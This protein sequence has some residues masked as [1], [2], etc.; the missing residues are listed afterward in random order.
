MTAKR[1]S[2]RRE[3]GVTN[4]KKFF[5][6]FLLS[7]CISIPQID[8]CTNIS[9]ENINPPYTVNINRVT[10]KGINVDDN[11]NVDLV[12]VDRIVDDVESCLNETFPDRIPES[13]TSHAWCYNPWEGNFRR[14]FDRNCLTIKIVDT[15]FLSNDG[16]QMVLDRN[17]DENLCAQKPNYVPDQG[18]HWRAGI[19]E[20]NT[21]VVCSDLYMF[22]DPLVRYLTSCYNPWYGDLATCARPRTIPIVGKWNE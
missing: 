5:I 8:E 17:A 20:D 4:M 11:N 12:L 13:I 21:I 22:P 2:R 18:C 14:N 19:Q 7:G 1:D 9:S 3:I 16:T 6:F 15:C 10:P